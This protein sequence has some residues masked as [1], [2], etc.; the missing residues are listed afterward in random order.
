[1]WVNRAGLPDEYA[2][3]PPAAVV[4]DLAGILGL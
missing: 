4:A 2:E 1:V 3:L